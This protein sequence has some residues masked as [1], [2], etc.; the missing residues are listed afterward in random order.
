MTALGLLTGRVGRDGVGVFALCLHVEDPAA[1]GG[2]A[3]R[4][5]TRLAAA[6]GR[7]RPG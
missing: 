2:R 6:L 5:L 4:L 3:S 1:P 7:D